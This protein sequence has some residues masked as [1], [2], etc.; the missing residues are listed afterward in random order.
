MIVGDKQT[1]KP[2]EP[3]L[4]LSNNGTNEEFIHIVMPV[5]QVNVLNPGVK[6]GYAGPNSGLNWGTV[7]DSILSSVEQRDAQGG[8]QVKYI[9]IGCK[10]FEINHVQYPSQA[11][12]APEGTHEHFS[13][14]MA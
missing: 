1:E 2:K 10:V 3:V 13:T 7:S 5:S 4:K 11:N 6:N 12:S 8:D 14:Q 9:E